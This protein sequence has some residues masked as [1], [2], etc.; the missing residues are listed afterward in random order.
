MLQTSELDVSA[1]RHFQQ[2][3][4]L[5]NHLQFEVF[6]YVIK[7]LRKYAFSVGWPY[8]SSTHIQLSK[9]MSSREASHVTHVTACVCLL[10]A[11]Y[12]C[13]MLPTENFAGAIPLFGNRHELILLNA[14]KRSTRLAFHKKMIAFAGLT[15]KKIA[16][17]FSGW[18]R[19]VSPAFWS[20]ASRYVSL[21]S[22]TIPGVAMGIYDAEVSW[23]L[24]SL[25]LQFN[26]DGSVLQLTY[27]PLKHHLVGIFMKHVGE[28][29]CK[30]V[31]RTVG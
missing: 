12:V 7:C 27:E 28:L 10:L 6:A 18:L 13:F 29:N 31:L 21:S 9:C 30:M 20:K 19:I 4:R 15:N 26:R 22:D 1:L 25:S 8:K 3:V 23:N 14:F 24:E 16:A 11:P 5:L 17:D 2:K